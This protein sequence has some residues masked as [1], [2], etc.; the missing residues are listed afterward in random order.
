M[1]IGRW[2]NNKNRVIGNWRVFLRLKVSAYDALSLLNEASTFNEASNPA[3]ASTFNEV[4]T[5]A[6]SSTFAELSIGNNANSMQ[7]L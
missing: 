4:S 5:F 2:E 6:E 3:E 1:Q 7:L